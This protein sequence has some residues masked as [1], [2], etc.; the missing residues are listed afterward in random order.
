M[1]KQKRKGISLLLAGILLLSGL[2]GLA[3]TEAKAEPSLTTVGQNIVRGKSVIASSVANNSGPELAVDGV[4]EA[5]QWNS[6][7]MKNWG[8]ASGNSKDD[9]EQTPQWI[10]IDR[11]ED[12]Q[13]AEVTSV[14]M[15]FN[16]KVWPMEYKI[17]TADT[18]D[19]TNT[20]GDTTV[21]LDKWTEVVSVER[22]S[23]AG[24]VANGQGQDIAD[25]NTNTDTITADSTPALNKDVKIKR[26]VLVYFTKVNAQ[27]P[28]NNINLREIEIFDDT[29]QV[30]VDAILNKIT[31]ES[32]SVEDGKIVPRDEV[33]GARIYVRGSDLENV[34]DNDG[35]LSGYNIG[36]RTVTLIARVE[37]ESD[38]GDYA[39]K[40]LT[41]TIPDS[42]GNYPAEL[43]PAVT[44]ANAKPEVVPGL[45]EWYGYNGDFELT[46]NSRIIYNDKAGVGLEAVAANM[47]TDLLEITGLDLEAVPG[48]APSAPE[49]IYIESQTDDTYKVGA[50]G[51]L[52][53]TDDRGLCIYAPAK[54]GCLYGTITAEQI[55]YQADGNRTVPKGITRDYPA[56]EI[57][58]LMLDVARTPYRLQQLK[59]YSKMLLWYKINEWQLHVNDNDNSNIG[60]D[61][62][63]TTKNHAGFFRLESDIFPSLVSEV[64][65][66]GIPSDLINDEYYLDNED[67]QGNPQYTK[68]EWKELQ[69]SCAQLGI[70]M[71]TEIDFPGHSLLFNKYAEENP[72]NIKEL[73]GG[74]AYT[75]DRVGTNGGDELIDLEGENAERA[76]WFAKTLWNEYTEGEDPVISGSVVNIGADEYWD[77][78]PKDEFASFA[79]ELRKVIQGNLGEDTK[80]RMFGAGSSMFSTAKN[81]FPEVDLPANYQ[82]DIWHHSYDNAK[83]RAAEGYQV[84]N[85]RDAYV[86][87]NPGRTNR[88][89]PNAEYLFNE[90][91]P[92][93]FQDGAPGQNSNPLLGE[94]NLLG[95]KTMIWG[96]QSQE[97]MTER[98]IH[99]RVL[100]AVS[101]LSEKTWGGTDAD[102]TFEE[103]EQRAARLAEGPG[104]EIAMDVE[105]ATSL[106]LDYDFSNLSSDGMTV[107]DA[108]GNGYNATLPSAG[109]VSEDGYLTLTGDALTTPLKTLS[110]PYTAAFSLRVDADEAS[111]NTTKSSI[112]SGYDGQ[113]QIAGTDAGSLSANVNYFTRDFN[114]RVPS[115][116]N[117]V[118]VM[119]VGTFQGTRLYVNGELKT[120]LSQKSDQDGVAPGNVTT[121]YS[122]F[123]LPLEKIGD[124]LHAEIADLQVYNKAFSAEEAAAYYTDAWKAA[125][126]KTNVAQDTYAGGTSRQA[127]DAYDASDRRVNV[128]FK[129]VDGDAFTLKENPADQMD[130]NTS[131]LYSYWKGFHPDSSLCID[132][133]QERSI[134]ELQI[135]WRYGGKGKAFDIQVSGDGENWSTMKEVRGNQD[136]LTTITA[137]APVK[138]RYVRMQG[139]TSNSQSGYMIQEFLVYENV[140]KS[141][142]DETLAEAET[143]V[144]ENGLGFETEDKAGK[145]LY[146]AVV[147]A[148]AV[149]YNSLTSQE[150]YHTASDALTAALAAWKES[151]TEEPEPETATV[152]FETNGGSEVTSQTVIIGEKV[153][154]PEA[155]EKDG[156]QFEGWFTDEACTKAYD[157][158]TEVD[159]SF[160]L[161]A[162]W[163]KET[164]GED[165]DDGKDPVNPEDPDDGKDPVNP[166][167]PDDGKDPVNPGDDA[168]DKNPDNGKPA[169][170]SDVNSGKG[171]EAVNTGD[172][173]RAVWA[174]GLLLSCTAAAAVYSLKKR[175]NA[176]AE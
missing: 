1:K 97:G 94:P 52:M 19:L 49:D 80:I 112:L 134:S 101:I 125:E 100:R 74:I 89:V 44:G 113:L 111:A 142:I 41:V 5:P 93:I 68:E 92:A 132:L 145:A 38:P 63:G 107:Y 165:P 46:E 35:N 31:A 39:E 81:L 103:F 32:L 28:G 122:S 23:S 82:L 24:Q 50:E 42:T 72:D 83:A 33:E 21:D 73:E 71:I 150:E 95:A 55:L 104:T 40:N 105:S 4:C 137:D 58:G 43:F 56:Y 133:G 116:G 65:K 118:N 115:D 110:Y 15:W 87:G 164:G 96:D 29:V 75:A 17:L 66:A 146:D 11:G 84:I 117:T 114:Y 171:D 91:T 53:V 168:G 157:F 2:T 120:F 6:T 152:R 99:Q 127:G 135:Q 131:E 108:S 144:A 139:I 156:Y 149:R 18:S 3:S 54:T 167:D 13:D 119:I 141:G 48:N 166:E 106:V 129:A 126:V 88:D 143:I 123:P 102:D 85:C 36:E 47:K 98:D 26:Y 128:A 37:S 151:S 173:F 161:Y 30:D 159:G 124:G 162:K 9:A 163:T 45:Q 158:D 78:T 169:D 148:R 8:A 59:D 176:S 121:M 67:Y 172:D 64:K 16:A 77:H 79:E 61:G 86:Y 155:P 69:K 170:P 51:Y 60:T 12:A 175:R 14:K 10:Q 140:D 174:W 27:A 25:T 153:T 34:V 76:L 90:W 62:D 20:P 22:P 147:Q 154:E 160:T 7:D 109:K 138:A 130:T 136:F 57:R 70:N